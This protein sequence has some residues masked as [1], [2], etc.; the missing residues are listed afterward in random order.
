MVFIAL[1]L[2]NLWGFSGEVSI[3]PRGYWV[4]DVFKEH[5]HDRVLAR[6]LSLFFQEERASNL[7]DFGCGLGDYI[8]TFRAY[9][10][11]AIGYDGN[12]DTFLLSGGIAFPL[13]LSQ[14][15]NLGKMFDWVLSLEVGEHI[16]E[17]YED[18]FIG[19][20]DKHCIQGII[21]SWAIKGQGGFGH[22]NEKNNQY[23]KD[24]I[25]SYGYVN[26]IEAEK[27]FRSVSQ[28]KWFKNTI[29]VFRKK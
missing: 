6:E 14:V 8:K 12:P 16:P 23:I 13:D 1:L 18:I 21:L 3:D 19:N 5:V 24:K 4:G 10:I 15:V 11:D 7:V 26:D 20:L 25:C 28:L 22:F 9:G 2:S 27:H 29:M 17:E